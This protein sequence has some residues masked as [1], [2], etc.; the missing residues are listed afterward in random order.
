MADR[1]PI[2]KKVR[3][4][5]FKRDR[6]TCQYCGAKA[7]DA[8]LHVDHIR[9]VAEGGDNNI[10]NLVTACRDC[11]LGKGKRLL[12]DDAIVSAKRNQLEEL[13]ERREQIQMMYEWELSLVDSENDE[14][15]AVESL[16]HEMTG[17][18]F[19]DAGRKHIRSLCKKFGL[20]LVLRATRISF[21]H[22]SFGSQEEMDTAL[23][24]IGGIC[25]NM[26]HKRCHQCNQM[27]YRIDNDEVF[28]KVLNGRVDI[29]EAE[30]CGNYDPW[31]GGDAE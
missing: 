13:A 29:D 21:T 11:N 9:P 28:C 6:F 16:F 25:F 18:S 7:P 20:E 12:S 8:I 30:M 31:F 3:F 17:G 2:P 27:K 24:K 19:T 4:E 1:K 14:I 23:G 5:V 22:Y 26:T 10:L 15:D